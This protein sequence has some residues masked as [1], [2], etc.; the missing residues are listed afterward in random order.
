MKFDK[1]I[2]IAFMI[3]YYAVCL[4]FLQDVNIFVNLLV[5]I[6]LI[7]GGILAGFLGGIVND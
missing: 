4:I 3:G 2:C 5:L 1:K 6:V 7:G